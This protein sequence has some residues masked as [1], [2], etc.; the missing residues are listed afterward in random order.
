MCDNKQCKQIMQVKR[1]AECLAGRR[2]LTNQHPTKW[3][4]RSVNNLINLEKMKRGYDQDILA[5]RL[6]SFAHVCLWWT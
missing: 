3:D 5:S 4:E 2:L 6:S 1:V